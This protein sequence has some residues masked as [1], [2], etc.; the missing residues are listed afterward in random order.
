MCGTLV[1]MPRYT[2]PIFPVKKVVN[3]TAE[4]AVR[5]RDYRFEHRI[6][7]ENE[8]IRQLID[9]GLKSQDKIP[10]RGSK[11]EPE[12]GGAEPEGSS[13]AGESAPPKPG[14]SA[15]RPKAA[16][17]TKEAQLRALREQSAS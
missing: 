14:G 8:A 2:A 1:F 4:Q 6:E 12:A 13:K 16:P 10:I 9:A 15:R 7:S 3:L 11:P 17:L 5:I